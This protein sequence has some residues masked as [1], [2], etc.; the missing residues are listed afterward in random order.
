MV[1][2]CARRRNTFLIDARTVFPAIDAARGI[3]SAAVIGV[4]GEATIALAIAD[5]VIIRFAL[6]NPA[7]AISAKN[8]TRMS[9]G[10]RIAGRRA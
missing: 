5:Q 9:L 2:L 1:V 4:V 8:F 6:R 3:F 10:R 7:N